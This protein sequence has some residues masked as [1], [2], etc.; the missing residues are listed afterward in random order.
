MSE[1]NRYPSSQNW[2]VTVTLH[3]LNAGWN[4]LKERKETK[5]LAQMR[6]GAGEGTRTHT[7]FSSGD[8]WQRIEGLHLSNNHLAPS[9][10]LR[11]PF[12]HTGIRLLKRATNP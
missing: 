5:V 10:P 1:S 11:L 6:L 12:R 4:R 9:S 8:F 7:K 2:R 3:S